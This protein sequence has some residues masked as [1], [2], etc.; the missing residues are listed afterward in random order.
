MRVYQLFIIYASAIISSSHFTCDRS[1][2]VISCS[3][4]LS[5]TTSYNPTVFLHVA[6]LFNEPAAIITCTC[7][8]RG[9]C[10]VSW[11][12]ETEW[13]ASVD[14]VAGIIHHNTSDVA[15]KY[16]NIAYVKYGSLVLPKHII[17]RHCLSC[18]CRI[19]G[20]T[21]YS[22]NRCPAPISDRYIEPRHRNQRVCICVIS[23]S[24]IVW[25]IAFIWLMR[26]NHTSL[27]SIDDAKE[28]MLDQTCATG[29]EFSTSNGDTNESIL[30]NVT[31]LVATRDFS[32]N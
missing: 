6:S 23:S 16:I 28:R 26:I 9:T 8:H 13:C 25:F 14:I 1:S 4:G 32:D 5:G 20:V 18:T 17:D 27:H 29:S 10:T 11:Y 2:G 30:G 19:E 12:V 22:W 31:S 3:R 15:D 21:I 24:L 7:P